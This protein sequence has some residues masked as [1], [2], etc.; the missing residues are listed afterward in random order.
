MAA[1]DEACVQQYGMH[2]V[3]LQLQCADNEKHT[4][5]VSYAISG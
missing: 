2:G 1:P 5:W 3:T 4:F